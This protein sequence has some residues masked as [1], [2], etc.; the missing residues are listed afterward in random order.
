[1]FLAFHSQHFPDKR[2]K[3]ER[4]VSYH[5][6]FFSL[7][8]LA[9]Y[10]IRSFKFIVIV[11]MINTNQVLFTMCFPVEIKSLVSYDSKNICA[12]L[13]VV[14]FAQL[15]DFLNQ[16]FYAFRDDIIFIVMCGTVFPCNTVHSA[17]ILTVKPLHIIPVI[18]VFDVLDY[19]GH[20]QHIFF[21]PFFR[22]ISFDIT[23]YETRSL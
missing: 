5:I 19:Q 9:F 11:N 10:C 17:Y 22:D 23:H 13:S 12:Q 8:D 18:I 16:T 3:S 15:M 14:F 7:Q 6:Y 21:L 2:R 1:M 20:D 4:Y